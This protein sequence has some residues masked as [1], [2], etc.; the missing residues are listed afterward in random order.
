MKAL[1]SKLRHELRVWWSRQV[2]IDVYATLRCP[3]CG[4]VFVSGDKSTDFSTVYSRVMCKCP[5]CEAVWAQD[6]V[7][8]YESWKVVGIDEVNAREE[9]KLGEQL[10]AMQKQEREVLGIKR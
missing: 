5:R 2:L 4:L 10:R 6:P 9:F 3:G 8:P 1:L 7:I